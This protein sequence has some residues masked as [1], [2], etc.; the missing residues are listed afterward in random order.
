MLIKRISLVLCALIC[1]TSCKDTNDE[2]GNDDPIKPVTADVTYK[3]NGGADM[4]LICDLTVNYTDVAGK[5]VSEQIATL[6]WSKSIAAAEVPFTAHMKLDIAPRENYEEK[7]SY[8]VGVGFGLS[9]TTTDGQYHNSEVNGAT[10]I[11]KDKVATYIA[12]LQEKANESTTTIEKS[13]KE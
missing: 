9:Y 3:I 8:K 6:P 12:A 7:S 1:L 11:S 5:T 2:K 10:S 13:A 4:T